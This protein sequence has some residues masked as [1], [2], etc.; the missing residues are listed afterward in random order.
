MSSTASGMEKGLDD[1][2]L[3]EW[4][5]QCM[6]RRRKEEERK[7]GE[8]DGYRPPQVHSRLVGSALDWTEA[9]H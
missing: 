7:G 6:Y 3:D 8:V 5:R 9:R 4:H 1:G 2:V